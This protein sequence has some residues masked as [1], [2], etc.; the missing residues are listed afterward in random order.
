MHH[1]G[2]TGLGA[3]AAALVLGASAA[4]Q[5]EPLTIYDFEEG[6]QEWAIPDWAKE[7]EDDVGRV[8]SQ[9]TETA[10]RGKGSMQLLADF[11]GGV[12]TGA[13]VE[14]FMYVTDWSQFS[15][16]SVDVY[17]PPNAPTGL[18]GRII[19]TVGDQWTWTDMNRA[20]KLEPGKW[21]TITA[22]LKPGSL[23]WKFFPTEAFRKD[24]R[25]VGFRVESDKKP[26]YSGPIY[27]DNIRLTP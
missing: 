13:Y 18:A 3:L 17:L 12:W 6:L 25:K 14:V 2:R 11:P 4:A 26:A 23:D 22:N 7:K 21:T 19:L 20:V 15:A 9:S 10:S 1:A 5:G 8:L 16:I 27:I 24:I